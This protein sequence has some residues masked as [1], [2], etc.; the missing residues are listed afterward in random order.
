MGNQTLGYRT[1]TSVCFNDDVSCISKEQAH[2]NAV[3]RATYRLL[4]DG[5]LVL[6]D[7]E[8]FELV[9]EQRARK[10]STLAAFTSQLT[11]I[12]KAQ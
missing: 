3:D 1:V 9:L 5:R 10:A 6:R 7:A 11:P 8:L 4:P 2:M 12:G